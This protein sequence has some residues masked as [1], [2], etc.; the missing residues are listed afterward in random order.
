MESRRRSRYAIK[1]GNHAGNHAEESR[2]GITPRNHAGNIFHLS[3][4][5]SQTITRLSH[6]G[7]DSMTSLARLMSLFYS[8]CRQASSKK[9]DM[10]KVFSPCQSAR[11]SNIRFNQTIVSCDAMPGQQCSIE[12]CSCEYLKQAFQSSVC[13]MRCNARRCDTKAIAGPDETRQL[14]QMTTA[15]A[16]ARQPNQMKRQRQA[17]RRGGD[18]GGGGRANLY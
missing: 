3:Q 15:T 18:H 17:D 1:L 7:H 4:K 8:P 9:C 13:F 14:D 12:Q 16:T 11:L 10:M 2:Q 6:D 5:Q